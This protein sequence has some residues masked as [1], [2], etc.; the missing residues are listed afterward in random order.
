MVDQLVDQLLSLHPGAN[1]YTAPACGTK[2]CFI[3]AAAAGNI[4]TT[5]NKGTQAE[6]TSSLLL[7]DVYDLVQN[8]SSNS[9]LQQ[10]SFIALSNPWPQ[11]YEA[12]FVVTVV[13]R[14]V[15]IDEGKVERVLLT[16]C[17]LFSLK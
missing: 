2:K 10:K 11:K 9:H 6:P 15:G 16:L 4:I 1:Q 14:L 17:N 12:A 13:A 7:L 5:V 3:T 8:F